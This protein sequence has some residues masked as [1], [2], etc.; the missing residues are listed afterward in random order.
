MR[1]LIFYSVKRHSGY[2]LMGESDE[3]HDLGGTSALA[4]A[5]DFE[6]IARARRVIATTAKAWR[7]DA[8][9]FHVLKQVKR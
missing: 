1:I 5:R 3:P 6:T 9:N 8:A 4:E 2:F 7:S